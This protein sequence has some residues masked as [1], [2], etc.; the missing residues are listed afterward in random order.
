M[1]TPAV[2]TRIQSTPI[3]LTETG[4]RAASPGLPITRWALVAALMAAPLAFGAVQPWAWAALLIVSFGLLMSWTIGSVRHGEVRIHLS[5][6]YLP[7]LLFLVLCLTQLFAGFTFDAYATRESILKFLMV[8]IF[9]FVAGQVLAGAHNAA[10]RGLALAVTLYTFALGLFAILQFFSSHNLIYWCIRSDGW[11]FGPYVNHNDYAGLM[12]MLIPIAGAYVLSRLRTDPR[13]LLLGFALCVP[14][15]S[16]WLSGSRGGFV[17]LL[18]EALVLGAVLWRRSGDDG[19]RFLSMLPI[20]LAAAAVLFFW[21][22]PGKVVMRLGRLADLTHTTQ[23]TLAQRE[24][25]A[26]DSL[27]IFRDHPWVGIGL[28]SFDAVFPQYRTFPTDL[29]WTH[30]HND[31]AE[32]LAETGVAGGVLIAYAL[33][34]FFR[35]AFRN[36]SVQRWQEAEWVQFG[37]ALGCCGLLVHSFVDFNLHIPANALWFA[38]AVALATAPTAATKAREI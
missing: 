14:V 15:A 19:I 23:T 10:W 1:A 36:L 30:A 28:G 13:R 21:M 8:L 7:A 25:A 12:E 22:A 38:V 17:S 37:A 11:T 2:T 9:F 29:E 26:R 16:V 27:R 34:L 18:V 3:E 4:R 35:R 32:V 20:G 31:Y 33:L 24:L 6:L 5:P